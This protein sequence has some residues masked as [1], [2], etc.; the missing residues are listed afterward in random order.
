MK[1]NFIPL[2]IGL[3][4]SPVAAAMA[5]LIIYEEYSHHYPDKKK[6]LKFAFEAGIITL[7]IFGMLSLLAS[8]FI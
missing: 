1:I 5:F 3:V 8:L 2:F 4:L 7:I 6:P